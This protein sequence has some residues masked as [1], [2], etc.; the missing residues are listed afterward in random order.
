MMSEREVQ[1]WV[2]SCSKKHIVAAIEE[3]SEGWALNGPCKATA[4]AILKKIR[5]MPVP[6]PAGNQQ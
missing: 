2:W 6:Q 1:E 4:D 5:D 3:Y